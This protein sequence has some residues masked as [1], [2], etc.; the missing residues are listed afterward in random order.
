M[1]I[2]N[3]KIIHGN[4][5]EVM[6]N[7]SNITAIITDPPYGIEFMG[8]DW[9]S[10]KEDKG[11]KS[12][13]KKYQEWCMN[14]SKIEYDCCLPGAWLL[15]FGGTRTYHRL[16]CGLEDAGW[17]IRDCI[18]WI[19]GSGFPKSLNISKKIDKLSGGKEE[20][21]KWNG[22]GTGLKPAWEPIILARKP[23]NKTVINNCL[24]Y[25]C[26]GLNIGESKVPIDPRLDNPQL[27][28]MNRSKRNCDT[29][30]QKWGL[31]K[32]QND[33]PQ[34]VHP[35][36][37]WPSNLIYDGSDE[38]E[39]IF[40]KFGH[41]KSGDN[42]TRKKE[43]YFGAGDSKHF[44][45]GYPGDIQTTYGDK[46]SVSRFFYCAKASKS[47]KEEYNDHPTVKPIE[48][49]K[50]LLNLIKQPE[51]NL[52]LDPFAGSGSTLIAAAKIGIKCIGIER[53]ENYVSIIKKRL[54]SFYIKKYNKVGELW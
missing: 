33:N 9:D 52:V 11:N 24:K 16:A 12:Q 37:R 43:G 31:S 53:N 6:K 49:M 44:G 41:K 30:S 21:I 45:L 13:I 46:G 38:V 25:G 10:F 7:L 18:M 34:V 3:N 28:K 51:K 40:L 39:N 50:Y 47:E 26:G 29:S 23:I 48:L 1:R 4:C 32:N 2:I 20:V 19:Y 5:F 8:K 14:W 35:S 17:E 22:Y 36:G 42:C 27:R 15:C 54:K